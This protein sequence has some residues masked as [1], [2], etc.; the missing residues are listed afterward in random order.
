MNSSTGKEKSDLTATATSMDLLA[1]YVGNRLGRILVN[2][3][4]L[5]GNYDFKLTWSPDQVQD[6]PAPPL[7]TALR[8]QLGFGWNRRRRR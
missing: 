7:V 4:G 1:G 8:E 2:K 5:A 6:A 3:T